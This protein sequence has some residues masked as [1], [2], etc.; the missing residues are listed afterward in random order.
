MIFNRHSQLAGSHS[1]LTPSKPA[2]I[3]YT[4]DQLDK[5]YFTA[6]AAQRGSERHDLAHNLIYQRVR[7][8][9]TQ[10]T[11]NMYVNDCIGFRM[12]PEQPLYYSI[13]A[14]GTCDCISF[15]N[16]TLRISDYKSGTNEVGEKQLL[17]YAALFCLEYKIRPFIIKVE[18]RIYQNNEV[19]LYLPQP[20]EVFAVMDKIVTFDKRIK[21]IRE[22][23][24]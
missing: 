22:E 12:T 2:W 23:V 15:R 1:F 5:S 21:A 9:D 19:R 11:L 14:F 7:L 13:N 4:E 24:L 16:D 10:E 20:D 18:L 8:P 3:N 17:I 6:L